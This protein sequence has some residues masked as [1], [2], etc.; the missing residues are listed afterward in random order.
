MSVIFKNKTAVIEGFQYSNLINDSGGRMRHV[1][2]ATFINDTLINSVKS[3]I[4][5]F[6]CQFGFFKPED[7]WTSR[8][9]KQ[10][11]PF[12]VFKNLPETILNDIRTKKA[13]IV[14]TI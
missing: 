6:S 8:I 5:L 10:D 9:L 7:F 2:N 13:K 11:E 3:Y 14:I 4:V 12:T 1:G